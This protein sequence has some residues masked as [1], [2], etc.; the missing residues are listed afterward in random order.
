ML[1]D[2]MLLFLYGF[3]N[4]L[5][6]YTLD[7]MLLI[8][9]DRRKEYSSVLKLIPYIVY[10]VVGMF[11]FFWKGIAYINTIISIILVLLIAIN[12]NG[13]M[14]SKVTLAIIWTFLKTI[15]EVSMSLIYIDVFQMS[16]SEMGYNDLSKVIGNIYIG[17]ILIV[18][19]K[20]MQ[21]MLK[22][23][24]ANKITFMDVSQILIIPILSII[25]LY[26]FLQNS[27]NYN[28]EIV[29]I[30]VP[31][32][33]IVLIN[34]FFFYIIDYL[35]EV[36]QLKLNDEVQ[37]NQM[38]YYIKLE[39]NI[40]ITFERIR[41]VKHDLKHD[42]LYLKT[43]TS[44]NTE[45]ALKEIDEKLNFLIGEVLEDDFLEFTKNTKLN[46]FLNYKVLQIKKANIEFELKTNIEK[47]TNIDEF[48]MYIIL[49]N[50]IDNAIYNYNDEKAIDQK[51]KIKILEES[52]NLI[53]KIENPFRNK[54]IFENGFPIT[55]KLDKTMHG[56]GLKSIKKIV[57]D[58]NGY[59]KIKTNNHVFSLEIVLFD[60]I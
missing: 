58:K 32:V 31:I 53:I 16:L 42:L 17:L 8:F 50:A 9:L 25:I 19:I 46:I 44:D 23:S 57:D 52:T 33:L 38:D 54:L 40:H 49:G 21:L 12:F 18:I 29:L 7:N 27:L 55:S 39:E 59:F 3:L 10:F 22:K 48:N 51:I 26:A 37:K 34:F 30:L 13:K 15:V 41:T 11:T 43:R 24:N 35:K 60:E 45:E 47:N 1:T 5:S 14:K 2:K 20:L 4:V 56:V 6:L 36:Q 28:V